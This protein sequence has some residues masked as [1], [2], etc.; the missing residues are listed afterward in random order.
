MAVQQSIVRAGP[1]RAVAAFVVPSHI[2]ILVGAVRIDLGRKGDRP[3]V[4]RPHEGVDA[5]G[6]DASLE[7][8]RD[9]DKRLH[10]AN[11]TESAT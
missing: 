4:G 2:A 8:C 6:D 11:L 7:L 5:P 1:H 3:A 9:D 10:G